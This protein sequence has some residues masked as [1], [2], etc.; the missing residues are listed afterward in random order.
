MPVLESLL[1]KVAALNEYNFFKK[2]L[3]HRFFPVKLAKIFRTPFLPLAAF[4]H[5]KSQSTQGSK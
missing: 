3:K 2:R 5:S 4:E 1:N